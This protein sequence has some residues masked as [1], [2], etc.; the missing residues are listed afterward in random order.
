MCLRLNAWLG[1]Q[2][3]QEKEVMD[4]VSHSIMHN[5]TLNALGGL[6]SWVQDLSLNEV[7]L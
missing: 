6:V 1:Y 3:I 5:H 7:V 4:A 2:Y